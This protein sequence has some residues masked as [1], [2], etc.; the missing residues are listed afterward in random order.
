MR[1]VT[2]P[3]WGAPVADP[4]EGSG[5]GLPP[6]KNFFGDRAPPLI[7]GAGRPAP[8]PPPYLK[9]WIRNCAPP[10]CKQAL[11]FERQHMRETICKASR[12]EGGSP[13]E[14]K[15]VV[16]SLTARGS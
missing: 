5:G 3:I 6:L 2:S 9:V 16:F 1:H 14:E 15:I 8:P 10:P 13:R 4:G 7:S 11:T 12:N